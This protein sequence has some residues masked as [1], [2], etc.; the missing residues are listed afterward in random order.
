[1]VMKM[2]IY[3]LLKDE[4]EGKETVCVSEDANKIRKFICE[5]LDPNEDY[6]YLEIWENGINRLMTKGSY[7]LKV[8]A[9]ELI[10]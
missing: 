4:Q 2:K 10:Q 7:V 1:M 5:N 3:V 8:I 6:P 9:R